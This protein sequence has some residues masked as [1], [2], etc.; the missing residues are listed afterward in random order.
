MRGF[1]CGTDSV[2][3]RFTDIKHDI[4]FIIIHVFLKKIAH[5]SLVTDGILQMSNPPMLH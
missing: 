3:I 1:F 2:L 5:I 4:I